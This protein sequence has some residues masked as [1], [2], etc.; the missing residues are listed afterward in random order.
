MKIILILL[1]F[2]GV[3]SCSSGKSPSAAEVTISPPPEPIYTSTST[4]KPKPTSTIVLPESNWHLVRD[5]LEKRIIDIVIENQRVDRLFLLRIDPSLYQFNV[6]YDD[7]APK[8]LDEWQKLTGALVMFNGGYFRI[9]GD[10]YLPDGLMVVNGQAF[11][12]TYTGFGGMFAI[13]PRGPQL[14]W[15]VSHPYDSNESLLYALQSFP[16]LVEPG[17]LVGFPAEYEDH[18]M[19]RRT[20]LG[21]D[22]GGRFIILVTYG[23]YFTLHQLSDYLVNSDLDLDIAL[24][25]D[26]GPSSGILL[27][28]PRETIPATSLLPFVVTVLPR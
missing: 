4:S 25:L 10:R 24:N 8:T 13:T 27:A 28:D 22:R 19:A 12:E 21:Q 3:S 18:Q 16:V 9:L 6:V 17:G 2:L 14:R 23:Y 7:I 5:G 1:L 15:L 11:G 26:G 20:V